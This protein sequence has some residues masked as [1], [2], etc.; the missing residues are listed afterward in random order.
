MRNADEIL[1]R[2]EL[3]LQRVKEEIEALRMAAQILREK[4]DPPLAPPR[5]PA[6]ILRMR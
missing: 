5:K 3:E 6:K 1:Q 4:D 2:K